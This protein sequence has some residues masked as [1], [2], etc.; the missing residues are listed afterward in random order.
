MKQNNNTLSIAVAGLSGQGVIMFTKVLMAAFKE[1]PDYIIRTYE[2]LGTAHRGTLIFSHIR[3]SK[4]PNVSFII[5]PGEAD[6][7]VGF[8]PLEALRV[9]AFYLKT[10]GLVITNNRKIIPVYASIGKDFFSDEPRPKGYPELEE[11]YDY[12]RGIDSKIVSFNAT[13]AALDVGHYAIMNM[14]LLGATLG[15]GL[16]PINLEKVKGKIYELAPEGTADMNIAAL[17]K[18]VELYGQSGLN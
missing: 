4:S 14:I 3:I 13:K 9:G 10:G 7:L 18:G 15:S 5:S 17:D 1:D 2:V 16:V 12:F 11:I 6:I 8:E